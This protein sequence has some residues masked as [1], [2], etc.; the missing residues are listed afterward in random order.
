MIR[1][2]SEVPVHR[3]PPGFW[4]MLK[5][6][7]VLLGSLA[8]TLLFFWAIATGCVADPAG[9]DDR[10]GAI[11]GAT[12][13]AWSSDAGA[14][15]RAI[16]R[17]SKS[18]V[19]PPGRLDYLWRRPADTAVV[20]YEYQLVSSRDSVGWERE[21][22][23][24]THPVVWRVHQY[25]RCGDLSW[26]RFY[27]FRVRA[28]YADGPGPVAERVN[29]RPHKPDPPPPSPP[30]TM[31]TAPPDTTAPPAPPVP[32][33]GSSGTPPSGGG[34]N[35][36]PPAG[37]LSLSAAPIGSS[38]YYWTLTLEGATDCDV[39]WEIASGVGRLSHTSDTG[40]TLAIGQT[41]DPGATVRATCGK[42]AVTETFGPGGVE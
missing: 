31:T 2:P 19:A 5:S 29:D 13:A 25:A 37:A 36:P 8:F 16:R 3:V 21:G 22:V 28:V 24:D 15:P 11:V 34:G 27:T 12:A 32:G 26:S 38:G 17:L 30:D 23:C 41:S 10:D 18:S 20:A 7:C 42:N 40:A 6:F 39:E 1:F 4:G 35:T 33:G 14:D 9:F